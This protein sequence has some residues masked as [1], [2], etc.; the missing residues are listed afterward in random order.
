MSF[1]ERAEPAD[2][3]GGE[4]MSPG[5]PFRLD[6]YPHD[7]LGHLR[8]IAKRHPGGCVDLSVGD[9]CDPPP[10]VAVE[11]LAASGAEGG[12]PRSV[13]SEALRAAAAGWLAR[14]FEVEVAPEQVAAC[15]GTKELV[16]SLPHLLRLRGDDRDTV[17]HPAV[18]YATYAMGARLAGLRAVPVPLKGD[19][20]LDLAAV[21]DA[22]AARALCLWVNSPGNPTGAVEDLE[23]VAAWGR[24]RGVVVCSDECYVEFIWE[25]AR[26][27][28]AEPPRP[29]RT[30]LAHGSEG[31]LSVHSL[32]KRSNLAGLRV[33]FYT[34][35][36]ELVAFCAQARRHLGLMV[37][38]PVQTA[39]V[40][41]LGDD[42][43][44]EIQRR[45]YR[46][47]LERLA[48]LLEGLGLDAP[49]PAG[50]FYLWVPAPGGD[51]WALAERLA[52][53]AG[54]LVSPGEF[55]GPTGS[56]HIRLA[57]TVPDDRLT[58]LTERLRDVV[59]SPPASA[60]EISMTEAESL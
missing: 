26:P 55:Y 19:G 32:S 8:A 35:D 13:G 1:V 57:A 16:A 46:G 48:E 7:R 17:L 22:D 42:D 27:V 24:E 30:I 45:R 21:D 31:V 6:P 41:A 34:G 4:P 44:V 39:A 23:A 9:P 51:A 60:N 14:R 38:G 58:L 54:V 36:A 28:D 12:Y 20:R 3:C 33:G 50:A 11:A 49:L 5:A 59:G 18:S 53:D 43:H 52:T 47:R 25:R 2:C 15:V 37:P 29:P 10:R 40:A 56:G